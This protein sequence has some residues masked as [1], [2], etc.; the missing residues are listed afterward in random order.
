MQDKISCGC[1]TGFTKMGTGCYRTC[2]FVMSMIF[3][4]FLVFHVSLF[5]FLSGL[6]VHHVFFFFMVIVCHTN[7]DVAIDQC[8]INYGNCTIGNSVCKYLGPG[9][10]ECVCEQPNTILDASRFRC[11]CKENYFNQTVYSNDGKASYQC[12]GIFFLNEIL[13]STASSSAC[14]Q[15]V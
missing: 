15:R 10:S 8:A 4:M 7:I 3:L 13:P 9:L 2:I 14:A 11:K 1:R 5:I 12:A 6:D